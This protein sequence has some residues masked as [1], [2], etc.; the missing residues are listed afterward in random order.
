MTN[1]YCAKDVLP[2]IYNGRLFIRGVG[3]AP[4]SLLVVHKLI[5]GESIVVDAKKSN[6]YERSLLYIYILI[7]RLICIGCLWLLS[8]KYCHNP[9]LGLAT[10]ARACK[11]ASQEGSSEV[12]SHAPENVGECE[13]MN[14]HIHK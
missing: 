7:C 13:G 8:V 3:G 4:N 12:T 14:L 1:L 10:K 6:I 5:N 9:S 11:G 2:R